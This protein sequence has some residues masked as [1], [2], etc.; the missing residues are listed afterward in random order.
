MATLPEL[1]GRW[2]IL[3]PLLYMS[4]YEYMLIT[5]TTKFSMKQY[6]RCQQ[7]RDTVP[8]SRTHTW[9]VWYNAGGG[10]GLFGLLSSTWHRSEILGIS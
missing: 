8:V 6:R 5:N 3:N 10:S 4:I 2:K 7:R 1:P 9:R